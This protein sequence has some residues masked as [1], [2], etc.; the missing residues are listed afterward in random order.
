[1]TAAPTLP[2]PLDERERQRLTV[3]DALDARKT[4]EERNRLGQFAT[5]PALA[6]DIVRFLH[7]LLPAHRPVRFLEP[8]M[9]TGAFCSALL[10]GLPAGSSGVGYEL[11]PAFASAAQALWEDFPLD[12]RPGD[13][14][15]AEPDEP[16][17]DL[18]VSNPP[19][20]R[21]HHLS[22]PDKVRL[23]GL[24]EVRAGIRPSGYTGLYGHF[25][26]LAHPWV[27]PG[28]HSVWLIP[29][30]FM[31]VGYGKALQQYLTQE[32]TLLRLHRFDPRAAQFADALV[33]SA[34]LVL[35]HERPPE[36]HQ[37]HF[38]Y[39]GTLATPQHNETVPL[40]TLTTSAKWSRF[41]MPPSDEPAPTAETR[42]KDF[43]DIRR[44]AATGDNSFFVLSEDRAHELGLP[45]AF[46]RPV[47]PSPRYLK[48]DEVIG[49][50][51]GLPLLPQR[52]FLLDCDL[53]VGTVEREQPA[54]WAYLRQGIE[55]EVSD[56]YLC[57]NRS[58]WYRQ[59]RRPPPPFLCTYMGRSQEGNPFRFILNTSQATATNV[60]LLLYPK[61]AMK[62][63]LEERP[64]LQ[65][66]VW[67]ELNALGADLLKGEGRVYG[68]GLHKLEPRE[69]AN[70][71]ADRISA[72]L[73]APV[74]TR[75]PHLLQAE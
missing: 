22:P 9:G 24:S 66:E 16:G 40:A 42:L 44:G 32:V 3:Q 31:D 10:S 70:A 58:P 74:A 47:L 69:L 60:Y 63:A 57:A 18:L 27:R 36:G 17:F 61:G 2:L 73:G 14:T 35:R 20:V 56:R 67:R 34:I 33:S 71:P 30:E 19:Y 26:L 72:L 38:S 28:G 12:V 51:D 68:G 1:M 53:D 41:G 39:G 23:R 64:D 4:R 45:A 8:A 25:L 75:Q 49:D 48:T 21:H 15:R 65:R 50:A 7:T 6:G 43:F 13:F 11:D 5:P 37:A 46:L 62:R 54:L 59:E 52:L 55:R 29:S